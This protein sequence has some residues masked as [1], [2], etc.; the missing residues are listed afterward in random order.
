[1]IE[2]TEFTP[3]LLEKSGIYMILNTKNGKMY[4]GST[5]NFKARKKDH[6]ERL[7]SGTH[8][9]RYLLRAFECGKYAQTDF[10]FVLVELVENTSLMLIREQHYLDILWEQYYDIKYNI[11]RYAGAPMRG[12]KH[13]AEARAK[14]GEAS[15]NMS[16][17]SRQKWQES[18]K[19]R[20]PATQETRNKLRIANLGKKHTEETKKKISE[21]KTNPSDET[22][23]KMRQAKLG[24][25][26]TEEHK[27][28]IG[29]ASRN[30]S[31]ETREKLRIS[32]TGRKHTEESKQ[33][34]SEIQKSLFNEERVAKMRMIALNRSDEYKEN[35]SKR[36]MGHEVSQET[37][38]KIK[39]TKTLRYYQRITSEWP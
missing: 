21:V 23:E 7:K 34:M 32:S 24:G 14:I 11:A 36:M 29:E 8:G 19:N 18:M 22:R 5:N 17:E 13:S 33:K 31:D 35:M 39:K 27:A 20:P 15:R 16:E 4:I 28:K 38:D 26:L 3:E 9:N 37:I 10:I 2:Y 30:L 12:L 25:K 1:M 6:F